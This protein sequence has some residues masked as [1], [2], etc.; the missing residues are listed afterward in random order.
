MK[1]IRQIGQSYS[2]LGGFFLL[3]LRCDNPTNKI[4]IVRFDFSRDRSLGPLPLMLG[5]V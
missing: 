5:R 1:H 3:S 2:E 4:G